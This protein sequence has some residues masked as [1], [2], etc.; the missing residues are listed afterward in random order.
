M[1]QTHK[2]PM[3]IRMGWLGRLLRAPA[4]HFVLAGIALFMVDRWWAF[5]DEAALRDPT[6]KPVVIGKSRVEKIR[7]DFQRRHGTMPSEAEEKALLDQEIDEELLY[8]EAIGRRLDVADRSIQWWLIK[9]MRFVAE[10][11][12]LDEAQLYAQAKELGLDED[13]VVIR[14]ILAQKMRL[15]A[16]LA[17]GP[18]DPSDAEVRAYFDENQADW[19][20]PA[21]VSLRHVFL[22]RDRRGDQLNADALALREQLEGAGPEDAD[23]VGDPF[24]LGRTHRARSE[25]QLAKLFG[26]EFAKQAMGLETGKWVGPVPSAYGA[27]L[28]YVDEKMDSAPSSLDSVRNQVSRRLAAERRAAVLERELARMRDKYEV[29]VEKPEDDGGVADAS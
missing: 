7:Q 21:R 28:V 1:T 12:G 8:R 29:V 26:P 4:F 25:Q 15:V 22:S 5:Q 3:F 10:D 2:T 18:V 24:P 11:P 20:R 13:D 14:R 6:A 19:I 9:K 23:E 16:E 17:E 27:H